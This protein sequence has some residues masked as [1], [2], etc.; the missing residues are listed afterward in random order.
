MA[1]LDSVASAAGAAGAA[2]ARCTRGPHDG[3]LN[4]RGGACKELLVSSAPSASKPLCAGFQ[5]LDRPEF[6]FVYDEKTKVTRRH[7]ATDACTAHPDASEDRILY[8]DKSHV[9]REISIHD[10][11]E[12]MRCVYTSKILFESSVMVC[13][14]AFWGFSGSTLDGFDRV[15]LTADQCRRTSRKVAIG[16]VTSLED[17]EDTALGLFAVDAIDSGEFLGEYTGVV[18]AKQAT[19]ESHDPYGLCYPSVFEGGQ[20]YISALEYGNVIRC[21][22]HSSRPNAR[23]LPMILDGVLHIF[24]FTTRAIQAGEQVFVDYGPSYWRCAGI[25]PIDC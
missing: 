20:L 2:G 17:V 16:H 24:C 12:I 18:Q 9:L 3:S 10:A 6:C 7:A 5:S 22:N 15:S 1:V 25:E 11:E 19:T 8:R 14:Y 23:F 4:I 21:I 13:N